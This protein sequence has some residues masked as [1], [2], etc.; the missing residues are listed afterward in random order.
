MRLIKGGG[1]GTS[2]LSIVNVLSSFEA[3]DLEPER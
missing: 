1:G 3:E 2:S